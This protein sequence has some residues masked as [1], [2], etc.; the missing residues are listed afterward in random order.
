MN[1]TTEE[2]TENITE[3]SLALTRLNDAELTSCFFKE[4][5]TKPEYSRI[6][7]RWALLKSLNKKVP[8]REIAK[9]LGVSLCKI[10][11][12]SRELRSENSVLKQMLS[13]IS[14]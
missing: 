13:E 4:L 6:A 3:L 12:G 11:R 7:A 5:F 14:S 2:I 1:L 9:K 10:T 8:Q